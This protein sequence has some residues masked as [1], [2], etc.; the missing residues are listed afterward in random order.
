MANGFVSSL[1]D[2]RRWDISSIPARWPRFQLASVGFVLHFGVFTAP[3][4]TFPHIRRLAH[5]RLAHVV[6]CRTIGCQR[7]ALRKPA[8]RLTYGSVVRVF[9]LKRARQACW[10]LKI[11]ERFPGFP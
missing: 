9:E 11:D 3:C 10:R 1:A 6:S 7:A 5:R 4:R 8:K 2:A